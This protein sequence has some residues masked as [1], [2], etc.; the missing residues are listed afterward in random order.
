MSVWENNMLLN[1]HIVMMDLSIAQNECQDL[2]ECI[3]A[4]C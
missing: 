1:E 2:T 3:E 4:A